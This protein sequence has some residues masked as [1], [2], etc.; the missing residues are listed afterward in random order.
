MLKL[1]EEGEDCVVCYEPVAP[2]FT[3]STSTNGQCNCRRPYHF[4]CHA[5]YTGYAVYADS[6]RRI[7]D[8]WC[9]ATRTQ[10]IVGPVM[11][12]FIHVLCADVLWI[13]AL[14]TAMMSGYP[15]Q[16]CMH[17]RSDLPANVTRLCTLAYTFRLVQSAASLC[18]V[19]I[20]AAWLL[21]RFS[22]SLV[23]G[24]V[25]LGVLLRAIWTMKMSLIIFFVCFCTSLFPS[26]LRSAHS[27][28]TGVLRESC[29]G[30]R[31]P[32]TFC[33][34]ATMAAYIRTEE[35][36]YSAIILLSGRPENSPAY[37]YDVAVH[38]TGNWTKLHALCASHPATTFRLSMPIGYRADSVWAGNWCGWSCHIFRLATLRPFIEWLTVDFYH[39]TRGIIEYTVYRGVSLPLLIRYLLVT[40]PLVLLAISRV[41][42]RRA[43]RALVFFLFCTLVE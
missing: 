17:C 21:S 26:M 16:R 29:R 33:P 6:S 9:A 15:A 12:A 39:E 4:A 41:E 30:A 14:C 7:A 42:K 20:W 1:I 2:F 8:S 34:C 25:F 18:I 37:Y 24:L 13:L 19:A 27:A 23:V 10:W 32:G 40:P 11:A 5:A 36:A 35:A 28:E 38:P 3:S 43:S 22:T 31:L